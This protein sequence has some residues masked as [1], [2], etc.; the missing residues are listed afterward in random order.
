M[1]PFCLTGKPPAVKNVFNYKNKNFI[2][3]QQPFPTASIDTIKQC[4]SNKIPIEHTLFEKHALQL[5]QESH[6]L[7]Y[8]YNEE[9]NK[10]TT[11][12]NN[13]NNNNQSLIS[14]KLT[15]EQKKESIKTIFR[16][17][18]STN[19]SDFTDNNNNNKNQSLSELIKQ[20]SENHRI[21]STNESDEVFR[22]SRFSHAVEFSQNKQ[23]YID[24]NMMTLPDN[25]NNKNLALQIDCNFEIFSAA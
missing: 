2:T 13:N 1:V 20:I 17:V 12:N 5:Q 22:G 21:T 25:N 9:D 11:D 24:K 14:S 15:I 16:S 8:D 10:I 4:V 7:P 3:L 6:E 18:M 19:N 23:I